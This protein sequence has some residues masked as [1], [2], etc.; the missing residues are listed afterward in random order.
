MHNVGP[1]AAQ[2]LATRQALLT[3]AL[4]LLEH[5]SLGSLSLR[6]VS[7]SAGIVPA[8][9]Y[10]HFP[11][12]ES[13]GVALVERSLG[14]LRTALRTV[15]AGITGSDEIARRS[16]DV[17][18]REVRAHREEF[19]FIA[20]ERYGGMGAVRQAIRD[21]LRLFSD[22]LAADLRTGNAAAAPVLAGWEH[23]DVRMLTDLIVNHMVATAAAVL[24][25]PPGQPA[26]ER[27]VIETARRQLLL[28]VVGGR[29]WL[30]PA[31]RRSP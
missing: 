26:A 29:H 13:L 2:K 31:P 23:D 27:R 14:A 22:E 19:R 18:V 25:A 16:I 4:R 12:M 5:Q 1:R 15:R 3:A 20:R 21:Q 11:D 9:F 8:G 24:D 6:E 17:L 10:R 28:I 7:R 30:D